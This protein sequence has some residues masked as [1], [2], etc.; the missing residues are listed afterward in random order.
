MYNEIIWYKVALILIESERFQVLA[1]GLIMVI[2]D[3]K[4]KI[5]L[6]IF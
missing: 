4:K 3:Y 2:Q 1:E 5:V 6:K